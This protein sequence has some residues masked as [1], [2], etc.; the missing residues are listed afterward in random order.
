MTRAWNGRAVT[1]AVAHVVTQAGGICALCGHHGAN[2]LDHIKPRHTHPELTWDPTNWQ[3]AHL[4]A[5]G[6]PHGCQTPSC[7]C[8][9]NR[10]KSTKTNDTAVTASTPDT[11][12]P[13][14]DW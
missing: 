8:I 9:G 1:A 13:S 4:L 3:A 7:H 5:A 11:V 2:S 12:T 14:R 10:G 6:K